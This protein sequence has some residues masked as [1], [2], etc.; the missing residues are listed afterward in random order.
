MLFDGRTSDG[1][2]DEARHLVAR[3]ERLLEP[4]LARHA[5]VVGVRQDRARHPLGIALRLQDLDAAERMVLLIRIALVVEVVQQRDGAPV[6]L[7]LAELPRVAAHRRL[8][9]QHVLAQALA[10]RV[11]GHQRPRVFSR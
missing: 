8:D 6:V 7:V 11:L 9:A 1:G 4:R 2:G 5:G 3:V 10:L